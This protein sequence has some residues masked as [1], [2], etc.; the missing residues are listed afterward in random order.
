MSISEPRQTKDKQDKVVKLCDVAMHPVFFLKVETGELFRS[1]MITL[2]IEAL[3]NK[4]NIKV[5]DDNWVVLKNR[6]FFDKLIPHRIQN[7][8]VKTVQDSYKKDGKIIANE[9]LLE[10]QPAPAEGG[11][12]KKLIEE[13]D[14]TEYKQ[15]LK[16]SIKPIPIADTKY[17]PNPTK[18]AISQA[19]TRKPE[20]KLFKEPAEGKTE[21]FIAEFLLPECVSR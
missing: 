18:L 14:A 20:Y 2:I 16:K 13:I 8:D 11:V 10:L 9:P 12:N 15:A 21:K 3:D 7:R 5:K 19:N 1:F 4:Y 6:K 17:I